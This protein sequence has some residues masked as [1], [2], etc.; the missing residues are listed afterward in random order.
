MRYDKRLLCTFVTKWMGWLAAVLA[1][2]LLALVL[3]AIQKGLRVQHSA[4]TVVSDLRTTNQFFSQRADF[5]APAAAQRQVEQLEVLLTQL[6]TT[7]AA[8]T[9]QLAGLLPDMRSLL[10]AGQGD[11]TIAGRLRTVATTLQGG[12]ASLHRIAADANTTVTGVDDQLAVAIDLV[13]RLNTELRRTTTKLAPIPA[14][15]AIIPAPGGAR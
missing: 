6:N 15:D 8:D 4:H 13:G 1:A 2:V 10:A 3:V 7:G 14:Q 5:S 12:A 9:D 11:V